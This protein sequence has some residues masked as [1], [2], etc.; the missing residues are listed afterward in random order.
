MGRKM[1]YAYSM[2]MRIRIRVFNSKR[3]D[4]AVNRYFLANKVLEKL[5]VALEHLPKE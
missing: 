3:S 1:K 5:G 2:Q 4:E